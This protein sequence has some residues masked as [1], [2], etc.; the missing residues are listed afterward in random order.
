[1]RINPTAQELCESRGKATVQQQPLNQQQFNNNHSTTQL[2]KNE[3]CPYTERRNPGFG[4]GHRTISFGYLS[5]VI[6]A[7][8]EVRQTII[9]THPVLDIVCVC[10]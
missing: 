3:P 7:V 8:N 4:V 5:N 9:Y 1:M 6:F 2:A 10:V